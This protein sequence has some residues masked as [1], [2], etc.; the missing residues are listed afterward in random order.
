M[1][2]KDEVQFVIENDAYYA[3]RT[4]KE[5]KECVYGEEDLYRVVDNDYL[6]YGDTYIGC[7]KNLG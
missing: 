2:K 4:L 5:C 3:V 7:N 6:Y 1:N